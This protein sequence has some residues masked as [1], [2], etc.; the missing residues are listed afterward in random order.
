MNPA[1]DDVCLGVDLGGTKI[2]VGLVD[3]QGRVL[4][5]VTLPTPDGVDPIVDAMVTAIETLVDRT[6]RSVTGVGIGV[7]G[8]VDAD[9]SRVLMSPNVDW[10]DVALREAVAT[11]TDLPVVVENDANAAGWG[12]YRFGAGVGSDNLLL[13]TVGTGVGGALVLDG[14]LARGGFGMAGEVGHLR[15]VPQG[16]PCGCGQRGCLEQYGSGSALVRAAQEGVAAGIPE[17]AA[18]M[19]RAGSVEAVDGTLVTQAAQAGDPWCVELL[20]DLGRWLGEGVASMAALLDPAVVLVGGGVS[21]AGALLLDPMRAAMVE[22]LPA[23]GDRR[24]PRLE[25]ARLGN[26]AGLVGAADLGRPR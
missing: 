22:R 15:V 20:A 10:H 2:A 5:R 8:F 11:R 12:E 24:H 25:A 4:D 26:D 23:T 21:S 6:D 3:P 1:A 18:L 7:A 19:A 16:R 9:R 17:A 13:L 14:R